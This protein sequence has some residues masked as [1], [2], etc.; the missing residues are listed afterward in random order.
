LAKLAYYYHHNRLAVSDAFKRNDYTNNDDAFGRTTTSSI[1]PPAEAR[2]AE[3]NQ[4][5]GLRWFSD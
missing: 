5:R 1:K 2:S 3:A 4:G